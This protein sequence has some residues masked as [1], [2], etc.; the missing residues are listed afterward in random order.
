MQFL[1]AP[2]RYPLVECNHSLIQKVGVV[3][4]HQVYALH[5]ERYVV[6]ICHVEGIL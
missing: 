1:S 2:S 6:P 5:V 4:R 3:E